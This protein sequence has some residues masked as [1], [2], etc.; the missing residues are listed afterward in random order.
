ML[1]HFLMGIFLG[2]LFVKYEDINLS[3]RFLF[4]MG[5]SALIPDLEHVVFFF[6]YGRKTD[7]TRNLLK[8]MKKDGVIKGFYWY[9][10]K[11]HK[12][13]NSLYL[14]DGLL[15][16]LFLGIGFFLL[17]G[18][19]IYQAAFVFSLAF[20]YIYDIFEDYLMIGSLNN[21]WKRGSRAIKYLV[22]R[23]IHRRQ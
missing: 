1:I 13:Q 5:I 18:S 22:T 4:L 9:C 7:Y 15:P 21:N 23:A 16:V 14:H 3:T 19:K 17:D 12:S 2:L 20:H 6:T 10:A 11:N 8:Q